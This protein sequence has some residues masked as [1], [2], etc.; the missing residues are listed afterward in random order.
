MLCSLVMGRRWAVASWAELGWLGRWI[1][2]QSRIGLICLG[3]NLIEAAR[4]TVAG[5]V[6]GHRNPVCLARWIG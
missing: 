4:E 6:A 3:W 5:R 2:G 1:S